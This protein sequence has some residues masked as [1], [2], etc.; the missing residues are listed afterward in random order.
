MRARY[1]L[2]GGRSKELTRRNRQTQ[3]ALFNNSLVRLGEHALDPGLPRSELRERRPS[4][5]PGRV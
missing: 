3:V 5:R 2:N 1:E 4:G